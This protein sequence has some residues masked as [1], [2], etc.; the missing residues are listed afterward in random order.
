MPRLYDRAPVLRV[1]VLREE[2]VPIRL[3]SP[4][5]LV[6]A[7]RLSLALLV[8]LTERLLDEEPDIPETPPDR[9]ELALLMEPVL[10]VDVVLVPT[11]LVDDTTPLSWI[12]P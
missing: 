7:T 5:F 11:L 4:I 3:L 2:L 10:R 8:F 1:E 9:N 6:V 12:L